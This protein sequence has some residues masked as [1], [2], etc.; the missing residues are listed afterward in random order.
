MHSTT[1]RS[2][3]T[4]R[5]GILRKRTRLNP[6]TRRMLRQIENRHA[7]F[8]KPT[9]GRLA[10]F[11][12]RKFLSRESPHSSA[13]AARTPAERRW[14]K[15]STGFARNRR[16]IMKRFAIPVLVARIK[17]GIFA[18]RPVFWRLNT[19][20]QCR[21]MPG[22]PLCPKGS[23]LSQQRR[24]LEKLNNLALSGGNMRPLDP[25]ERQLI[26]E[27]LQYQASMSWDAVRS[28]LKLLYRA[29]GEA[30]REKALRFNLQDGGDPK[31]LG[32]ATEAKLEDIFGA[33]WRT[34]PHRQS[35]RD[36]VQTRL[37]NADY[38]QIG[39][40][41]VVIRTESECTGLRNDAEQSFIADFGAT[42]AEAAALKNLHLPSGWEPFSTAAL[43]QLLPHLE[44]GTRFGALLNRASLLLLL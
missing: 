36:A 42:A 1:S 11:W 9:A 16:N 31:L 29:R 18:Q 33:G 40:Q 24:T 28:A 19:F 21:F 10:N 23:W 4:L 44:A 13:I 27:K 25:E 22:E 14:N 12:Q 30:G 17:D 37:W 7:R 26:L 41:R 43:M 32:N 35:I 3:A 8:S 15:N 5:A 39:E 20:G 34:H 2:G 38:G 6:L